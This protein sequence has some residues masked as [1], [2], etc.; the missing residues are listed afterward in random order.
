MRIKGEDR[1]AMAVQ[2]PA[3]Q[4]DRGAAPVAADFDDA[5]GRNLS[6]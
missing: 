1:H 5:A 4:G 3:G 6:G 2:R